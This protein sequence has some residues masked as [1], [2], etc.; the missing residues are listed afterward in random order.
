M[1]DTTPPSAGL[2]R[3]LSLWRL[4][5]TSRLVPDD[6]GHPP[7]VLMAL[8]TEIDLDDPADVDAVLGDA[9]LTAALS[10]PPPNL[11]IKLFGRVFDCARPL[12]AELVALGLSL[13][14]L[15]AMTKMNARPSPDPAKGVD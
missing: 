9:G 15:P 14:A 8:A 5:A 13:R 7:E 4:D 1:V 11:R 3:A 10:P 2:Q 12:D 6:A